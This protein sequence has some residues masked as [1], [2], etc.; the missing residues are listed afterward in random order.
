MK[1]IKIDLEEFKQ[2][3]I[4]VEQN[5]ESF[6]NPGPNFVARPP[7]QVNINMDI[8]HNTYGQLSSWDNNITATSSSLTQQH[9]QFS[10]TTLTPFNNTIMKDILTELEA[11]DGKINALESK[12]DQLISTIS[13][14]V[15]VTNNP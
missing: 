2:R 12:L 6:T 10:A 11:K 4:E 13:T 15:P 5:V 1:E 7:S 3:V 9:S 8:I 14:L